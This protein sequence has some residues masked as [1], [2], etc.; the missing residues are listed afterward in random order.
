MGFYDG[1]G[2]QI[3]NFFTFFLGI[4]VNCNRFVEQCPQPI[5]WFFVCVCVDA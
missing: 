2:R 4:I 5:L 3:K 1:F